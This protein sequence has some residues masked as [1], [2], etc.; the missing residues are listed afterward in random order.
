MRERCELCECI[1]GD[2]MWHAVLL[3][4]VLAAVAHAEDNVRLD[5][6]L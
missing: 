4:R 6:A 2:V 3:M 1:N 5:A